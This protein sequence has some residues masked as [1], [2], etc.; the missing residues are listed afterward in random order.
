[1][2]CIYI[3]IYIYIYIQLQPNQTHS[4][5]IRLY[6]TVLPIRHSNIRLFSHKVTLHNTHTV[7]SLWSIEQHN[8]G[9][10]AER[11]QKKGNKIHFKSVKIRIG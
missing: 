11:R 3:N 6:F 8:H 7:V 4:S 1:M 9:G 10:P 5:S 2:L